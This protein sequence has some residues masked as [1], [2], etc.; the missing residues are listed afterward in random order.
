MGMKK[1]IAP[2]AAPS[3]QS[4]RV[5]FEGGLAPRAP[6]REPGERSWA[7]R[8]SKEELAP[9]LP[10][11]REPRVRGVFW[12]GFDADGDLESLRVALNRVP[13]TGWTIGPNYKTFLGDFECL[14]GAVPYRRVGFMVYAV[15]D[16]WQLEIAFREM[17]TYW[18][19]NEAEWERWKASLLPAMAARNVVELTE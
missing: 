2:A 17:G 19:S 14:F 7:A 5:P 18:G 15:G 8:P 11:D 9:W 10:T 1:R 3:G 13:N 6:K 16:R 4:A 12:C